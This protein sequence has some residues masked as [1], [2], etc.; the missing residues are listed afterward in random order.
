MYYIIIII[1]ILDKSKSGA[2]WVIYSY[3]L[4]FTW[5][6]C[7]AYVHYILGNKSVGSVYFIF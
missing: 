2:L 3:F 6:K 1:I 5:C 7:F 4:N